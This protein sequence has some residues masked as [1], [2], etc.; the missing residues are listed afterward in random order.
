[1]IYSVIPTDII[2]YDETQFEHRHVKLYNDLT[3]EMRGKTIE[4]VI[5]TNPRNFIKYST[6][7][8]REL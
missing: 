1:M 2:F 4:R 7:L 5:S 6:L 3:V 8:G